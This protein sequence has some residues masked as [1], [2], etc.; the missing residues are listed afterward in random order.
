MGNILNNL[1]LTVLD[2]IYLI[3]MLICAY[4]IKKGKFLSILLYICLAIIILHI[5]L[6]LVGR[7]TPFG[8]A[9]LVTSMIY[10][11]YIYKEIKN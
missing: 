1:S 4:L 9:S 7:W 6:I 2:I 5:C 11:Y 10:I 3:Y 8:I